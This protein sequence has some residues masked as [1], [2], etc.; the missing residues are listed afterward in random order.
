MTRL[1]ELAESSYEG[2][3]QIRK[4]GKDDA[5]KGSLKNNFPGIIASR[6]L[7]VHPNGEPTGT[8]RVTYDLAGRYTTLRGTAFC[9]P[10][11]G[12]PIS[13]EI[14]ADGKSLWIS[15][16][17]S[18]LKSAGAPFEVS[19]IG[20]RQL[21]LIATSEKEMYAAHVLWKEPKLFETAA[22]DAKSKPAP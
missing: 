2:F 20:V 19:V 5:A 17:L 11:R 4:V 9:R 7:I 8:C 18:Q 21:T 14:V 3:D 12:S 15:G 13:A 10:H 1:D 6:G 16:D 22:D